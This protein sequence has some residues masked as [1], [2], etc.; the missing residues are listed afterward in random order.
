[1]ILR[2]VVMRAATAVHPD[3]SPRKSGSARDQS[4]VKARRRTPIE[5]AGRVQQ[6]CSGYPP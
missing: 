5:A 3:G 6:G 2:S 1:M 4:V